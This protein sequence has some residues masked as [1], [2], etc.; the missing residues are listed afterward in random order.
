[1]FSSNNSQVTSDVT[2]YIEEVFSTDLYTGT[3]GTQT[4][5]NGIDLSTKGG[6][7]WVKG[8]SGGTNHNLVD[9]ARGTSSG[10]ITNVTDAA[11]SSSG[12][13]SFDTTGFTF[14]GGAGARNNNGTT[15]VAWTFR[16]Q[17]KFF[18]VV[19]F[20]GSQNYGGSGQT[21]SHNLGST[22][23][24]IIIKPLSDTSGTG[25]SGLNNWI[26]Y[27]RG[28]SS[29]TT[30]YLKLNTLAGVDG[31]SDKVKAVSST[32]F[33][34][35]W[36][37]GYTG[38][39]YVAYLFAHD[40]GGF[41]EAGTDNVISCGAFNTGESG[42]TTSVNLGYEPQWLMVKRYDGTASGFYD[43]WSIMDT[44]RA[45]AVTS[46][47]NL[48][49]ES[50]GAE[51]DWPGYDSGILTA[52]GFDIRPSAN[53]TVNTNMSYIYIAIRK[54]PMKV[55]TVGTSVFSTQV[56]TSPGGTYTMAA[57]SGFPIDWLITRQKSVVTDW[58]QTSRL[59][60]NYSSP[61]TTAG[62]ASYIYGFDLMQGVNAGWNT[63]TTVSYAFRRA[64]K[65]F[66]IVYYK[67]TGVTRTVSHNLTVVPQMMIVKRTSSTS[68]WSV[69]HVAMGATKYTLFDGS[70]ELTGPRW[71]NT[72]PTSSVFTVDASY[73]VN[74]SSSKYAAYL[75]ATLAG[76]SKVGS[77]TGTGA[78][79]TV[80]CGFT[81]G[82]RFLLIHRVDSG[83][84]NWFVYDSARGITSSTDPFLFLNSSN[85]EVTNTNYVDT[86]STGF[87]ITAAAPAELNA[88]GGTY[89]FLAIA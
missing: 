46:S 82:A 71:N 55:P 16:K 53:P 88:S 66:D 89:I 70:T 19:T 21:V 57:N 33:T 35:G 39:Q 32:T 31:N 86:H 24:C 65:F 68:E 34:A 60:N 40:A 9:T 50:A 67:G 59:I 41:G 54:G 6:L 85:A 36:E 48:Y 17:P 25:F 63:N 64:P 15:Y 5:T 8:R 81:S 18:D 20:T 12:F 23:G 77:Y 62:D 58:Y 43:H 75:F 27:H 22:P 42:V 72:S 7:V 51:I 87:Q 29:P 28:V 30:Q 61:N 45:M 47:K 3:D 49:A 83:S 37:V 73:Y 26:V 76:V 38:V 79:Q 4:I 74:D 2:K 13:T 80:D 56:Q 52:T 69:Y 44:T 11:G 84:N 1:M 14:G 10:L 78:L